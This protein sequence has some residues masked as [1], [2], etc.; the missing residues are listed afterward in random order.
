MSSYEE[1][2]FFEHR[3]LPYYFYTYR[4]SFVIALLEDGNF[5]FQLMDGL[6]E[7]DDDEYDDDHTV[8][9]TEED[10][11]CGLVYSKYD[12][13]VIMIE[14]P[15]PEKEMLCYSTFLFFDISFERPLFITV[16]HSEVSVEHHMPFICSWIP[17]E[18]G[19]FLH[20]V[21]H[22]CGLDNKENFFYAL[23]IYKKEFHL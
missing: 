16:E 3:I 7:E 1:M 20:M 18:K 19:N 21:Y 5:I 11:S 17:D 12:I 13:N 6:F 15:S 23:A 2:Y 10:F 22:N 14:Y 4:S 8:F 9:Y